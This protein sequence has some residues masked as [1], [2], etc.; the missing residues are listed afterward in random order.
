MF[1]DNSFIRTEINIVNFMLD[2]IAAD[3][4]ILITTQQNG[5]GG[6]QY[7]MIFYGQNK[8]RNITDTLKF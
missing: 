7:Q 1:C 4:H 8:F 2:R 6:R 5:S 3:V